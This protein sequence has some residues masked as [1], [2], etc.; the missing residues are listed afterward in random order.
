MS[1]KKI[2]MGRSAHHG[3]A[4]VATTMANGALPLQ[5]VGQAPAKNPACRITVRRHYRG[6]DWRKAENGWV[7]RLEWGK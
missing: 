1:L 6:D 5:P 3:A 4:I 7:V 2:E